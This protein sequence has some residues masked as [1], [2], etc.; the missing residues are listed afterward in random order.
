MIEFA[1]QC[2]QL[3]ARGCLGRNGGVAQLLQLQQPLLKRQRPWSGSEVLTG[4]SSEFPG[5]RLRGSRHAGGGHVESMNWYAPD[6]LA[7]G[8]VAW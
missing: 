7:P 4:Q 2:S 3:L 1:S 8:L 5:R 6:A